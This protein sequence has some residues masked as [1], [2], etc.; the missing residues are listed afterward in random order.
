MDFIP[1]QFYFKIFNRWGNLVFSTKDPLNP[2]WDGRDN[3]QLVPEG[4]YRYQLEYENE[5]GS[6][7]VLHGN[8]T[9]VRQ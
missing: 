6:M 8:V 3:N 4:V 5:V 7:H 1:K 9:V 2:R